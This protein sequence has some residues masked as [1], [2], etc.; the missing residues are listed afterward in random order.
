MTKGAK[1]AE[2]IVDSLEQVDLLFESRVAATQSAS[3]NAEHRALDITADESGHITA[4][5]DARKGA[6]PREDWEGKHHEG[7]VIA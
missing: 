1:G 6:I 4:S 5:H 3:W 7:V 2:L